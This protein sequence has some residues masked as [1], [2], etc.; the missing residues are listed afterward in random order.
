MLFLHSP[1]T[2]A[3]KNRTPEWKKMSQV[4]KKSNGNFDL[5]YVDSEVSMYVNLVKLSLDSNLIGYSMS[6][7]TDEI[8]IKVG[9]FLFV[10]LNH[11]NQTQGSA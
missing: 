4:C 10:N 7:N 11:L 1:Q 6:E 3:V 5:L 2:Q 8:V 9:L